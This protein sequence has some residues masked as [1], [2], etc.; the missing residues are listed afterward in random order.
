MSLYSTLEYTDSQL[1]L[2]LD[3]PTVEPLDTQILAYDAELGNIWIDNAART[4]FFVARNTSG[5]V[6]PKGSVVYITGASG[7]NPEIAMSRA[8]NGLQSD[9][10]VGI[11]SDTIG[12]NGRGNVI[13]EGAAN[14][15]NTQAF[16]EGDRLWL[17]ATTAGG[18]VA[19]RPEAPNHAVGIGIVTRSST[20][21][22]VIEV[23]VQVGEHLEYLHDVF[24]SDRVNNDVLVYESSTDLWK[25]RTISEILGYTPLQPSDLSGYATES[26]VTGQGYIT[27]S[28]LTPYLLSSTAA[29]TY[30]LIGDYATNTA[31]TNG[32]ATKAAVVHTHDASAIVTGTIDLA[33]IPI[34]P[35]QIQVVSTQDSIANLTPSEQAQITGA[36]VLVTTTDGRRWVYNGSGSKTSQA[37]YVELADI[38]PDWS[39]I[40]NKPAFGTAALANTEDFAPAGWNPFNQ[41]LN[42]G[43]FVQFSQVLAGYVHATDTGAGF[44]TSSLMGAWSFSQNRGVWIDTQGVLNTGQD[45]TG[46]YISIAGTGITFGDGTTQNTAATTPDLSGYAEKAVT[47]T[48]TA[49]QVISVTDNSNAA[50]RVTQLGTGEA[51]RV[52]DA[53]NPDSSPFVITSAGDVGIGGVPFSQQKL[54]VDGRIAVFAAGSEFNATSASN[55]LNVNQGGAGSAMTITNTA[56]AT[57]DAVRITNLGTGNSL[58][59]E[60]STNPDSSPFV[61]DAAGRVGIGTTSLG[62]NALSVSGTISVTSGGVFVSN[63]GGNAFTVS[64]GTAVPLTINNQG[65]GAS[66]RVN[67]EASDTTP[68]IVDAGGNVGVKTA[69]PAYDLDVNGT[70]KVSTLRFNDGTTLTTAPVV[71][72]NINVESVTA[73]D[74]TDPNYTA[75]FGGQ[76]MALKYDGVPYVEFSGP[77]VMF[78]AGINTNLVSY[79]G[80]SIGDGTNSVSL[81]ISGITFADGTIQSTAATG[82]D[83]S[84]NTTDAVQFQKTTYSTTAEGYEN[85]SVEVGTELSE[86]PAGFQVKDSSSGNTS[87]VSLGGF[88]VTEGSGT[89]ASVEPSTLSSTNADNVYVAIGSNLGGLY[90]YDPATG[91]GAF[92]FTSSGITFADGTTQST[93]ATSY[94]QSL[95]TTD[96]VSFG[97]VSWK[98]G[99]Y[100]LN[101]S[102]FE[103]Y[104]GTNIVS[105]NYTSVTFTDISVG[106]NTVYGFNG[107]TFPDNSSQ[108]KAY[109]FS[110]AVATAIE[111]G[112]LNANSPSSTNAFATLGDVESSVNAYAASVTPVLPT[113]DEKA[114]MSAA[115]T[116]SASNPFLTITGTPL[117]TET[118]TGILKLAN[119]TESLDYTN[120]LKPLSTKQALNFVRRFLLRRSWYTLQAGLTVQSTG[121]GASYSQI[122]TYANVNC[123]N[124][125]IAGFTRGY[126][127]INSGRP[128]VLSSFWSFSEP[129]GVGQTMFLNN[130][131][132]RV[133]TRLMCVMGENN[134]LTAGVVVGNP[135]AKRVG[136][137]WFVGSNMQLMVHNGSTLTFVD[138]GYA[139]TVDA[140][141]R[142]HYIE[143]GWDGSG[144]A[145]LYVKNSTGAEYSCTTNLAPTGGTAS[146]TNASFMLQY[147]TDGTQTVN[148]SNL[149]AGHPT[150][151]FP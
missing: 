108:T 23:R 115:D 27:A 50:L 56:T 6:I 65:T 4:L 28:A 133:G 64:S 113:T 150:F 60:D 140:F 12:I 14:K 70:A 98:N 130:A 136:W 33:R 49:N 85:I 10:V 38:T 118:V 83:Q 73:T 41:T 151:Y 87:I 36:G 90:I 22:G 147:S 149:S 112:L 99:D 17:S 139:P 128:D 124:A 102:G 47:N 34:I 69:S 109:P 63:T 95:N 29:S 62:A 42:T 72:G 71:G 103:G 135:T 55:I 97:S 18:L 76:T 19:T 110:G 54:R 96:S 111:G 88:N 2:K 116:P 68:F 21:N 122:V 48:F 100:G 30:Q 93:A 132:T 7:A 31:L 82:Y 94:D 24:V 26:W 45:T 127:I 81:N 59:V 114:A 32:L 120:D 117:G 52:E 39:V 126:T 13:V 61:I 125:L 86:F 121:T 92:G 46:G 129:A 84:L 105:I 79:Q 35:S 143:Y 134:T 15:L 131:A 40:T 74:A 89:S 146:V 138:L 141:S 66:F 145:Y 77:A 5:V 57:G 37:S 119:E 80:V 137:S 75:V 142:R 106:T 67:D 8:D 58:V 123:P 78:S 91:G 101:S 25:S 104:D 16:E 148:G 51:F 20:N 11:T 144:N 3:K 44:P 107:I 9:R 53:E 43:D 1:G